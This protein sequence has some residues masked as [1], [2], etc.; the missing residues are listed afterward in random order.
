MDSTLSSSS[1]ELCIRSPHSTIHRIIL[2]TMESFTKLDMTAA[3][4]PQLN[5]APRHVE[6]L[7]L[8]KDIPSNDHWV[9]LS[10]HFTSVKDLHLDSG[11]NERLNDRD[12][13]LH[14]PLEKITISSACGEAC[15]D[16]VDEWK[17]NK[18]AN[19][20]D[21][22]SDNTKPDSQLQTLEIAHNDTLSLVTSGD[23]DMNVCSERILETVLPRLT[24]LTTLV[25]VLG[26]NYADRD[27]LPTL[28]RSLPA[29]LETFRFQ[30]SVSL[31]RDD[32]MD[33]WVEAFANP[34]FL[35]RLK[36]LSVVLDLDDGEQDRAGNE[37]YLA[38]NTREEEDVV[39]DEAPFDISGL[40]ASFDPFACGDGSSSPSFPSSSPS[41]LDGDA[42]GPGMGA[43]GAASPPFSFPE[44]GSDDG[45]ARSDGQQDQPDWGFDSDMGS[46]MGSGPVM[47]GPPS[48]VSDETLALAK[49]A[50]E[51]L[52][53]AAESRGIAIEPFMGEWREEF[54]SLTRVDGRWD[55]V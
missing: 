28:F 25:L 35:P 7:Y 41:Q 19:G 47:G 16:L 22:T 44:D 39:S 52:E 54:T 36:R 48:N 5:N 27:Q 40:L 49:R 29:N 34:A 14:W 31:A 33:E 8:A 18:H 17:R 21:N 15:H 24:H 1:S 4:Q 55:G 45:D 30:S 46:D 13:P 12:I 10:N 53:R 11:W 43:H 9:L 38:N 32:V 50:C 42:T 2:L 26:D 6:K 37:A 23:N 51:R 3:L 20:T